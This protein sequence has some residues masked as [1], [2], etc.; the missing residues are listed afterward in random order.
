M[1]KYYIYHNPNHI[2]K[3]KNAGKI[4][5]IGCTDNLKKRNYNQPGEYII[6]EEHSNIY[7]ASRRERILQAEYGYPIDRIPYFKMIKNNRKAHTPK[8]RLK[9]VKNTDYAAKVKNMDYKAQSLKRTANTD[10][11]AVAKKLEKPII[12]FYIDNGEDIRDWDS[13]KIAGESSGVSKR[14]INNCLKNKAKSAGKGE[15]GRKYGWRY[16]YPQEK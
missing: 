7:M 3:G 8:A 4:G 13:Q 11:E 12:Q 6:L 14:N 15:N 10:Y 2:W 16:K 5:K 1:E 9:A